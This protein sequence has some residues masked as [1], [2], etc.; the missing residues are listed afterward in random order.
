MSRGTYVSNVVT[1]Y[2]LDNRLDFRQGQKFYSFAI[3]CIST[4]G[5]IQ[6]HRPLGG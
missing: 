5:L 3:A 1:S 4:L 2:G 6:H